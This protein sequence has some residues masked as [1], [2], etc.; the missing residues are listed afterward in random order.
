MELFKSTPAT[1]ILEVYI[2]KKD[3]FPVSRPQYSIFIPRSPLT[4]CLAI[5]SQQILFDTLNLT[6][7]GLIIGFLLIVLG[8]QA[9]GLAT[10]F[11]LSDDSTEILLSC[12]TLNIHHHHYH[13]V[14]GALFL[15]SS[16]RARARFQMSAPKAEETIPLS[17]VLA[18]PGMYA[19]TSF[20]SLPLR[21]SLTPS[22]ILSP[23]Y[24]CTQR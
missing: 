1:R 5:M 14:C 8:K 20:V 17:D 16:A 13:I 6:M 18:L 23:M 4:L 2:D 11:I 10:S 12:S 15:C 24:L 7:L 22:V 3:P 21:L 19:H 9:I